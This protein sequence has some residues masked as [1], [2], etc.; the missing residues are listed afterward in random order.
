M[1]HRAKHTRYDT[2]ND[3]VRASD[4]WVSHNLNET[5]KPRSSDE[6][7]LGRRRLHHSCE[8]RGKLRHRRA[9]LAA[10]IIFRFSTPTGFGLVGKTVC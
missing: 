6:R 4:P 9:R 7:G 5:S 10:I 1:I 3:A 2:G 8:L